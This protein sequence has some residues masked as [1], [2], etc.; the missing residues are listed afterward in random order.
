MHCTRQKGEEGRK[1]DS[2]GGLSKKEAA[3]ALKSLWQ[4]SSPSFFGVPKNPLPRLTLKQQRGRGVGTLARKEGGPRLSGT[5][6]EATKQKRRTKRNQVTAEADRASPGIFAGK[7]IRT[8][9]MKGARIERRETTMELITGL[10]GGGGGAQ[11]RKG[12]KKS[13]LVAHLPQTNFKVATRDPPKKK[14]AH[15]DNCALTRST[16]VRP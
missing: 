1:G 14:R 3:A 12:R 9:A 5:Q 15:Q 11:R 10:A 8:A 2:R 4:P 7:K 6:Q 16:E 13:G